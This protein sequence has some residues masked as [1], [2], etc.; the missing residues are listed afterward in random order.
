MRRYLSS[1][2][3]P[4]ETQHALVQLN[5]RMEAGEPNVESF[6]PLV[7]DLA[8]HERSEIR[9]MAAWVMGGDPKSEPFHDALRTLL[10]DSVPLVRRNAALALSKFDDAACR[11]ELLSMLQPFEV[12]SPSGGTITRM[13]KTGLP[14]QPEMELATLQRTN[15]P[16]RPV[17][18]PLGGKVLKVAV[19]D[20]DTVAEGDVLCTLG[21]A[22]ADM[23][24][25]LRAL[26]LVGKPSDVPVIREVAERAP[27]DR[28]A[29]QAAA[30]LSILEARQGQ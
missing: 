29:Q 7:A 23:W 1:N 16:P 20:G 22:E 5:K 4:R 30:T 9:K 27:S 15:A 14:V 24:E 28:V 26:V 19:T 25:A 18:S 2:E 17:P 10:V 21:P 12:T 3:K 6:Y 8:D 13:I 11:D